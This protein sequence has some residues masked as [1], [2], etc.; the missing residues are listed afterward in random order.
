MAFTFVEPKT[1]RIDIGDG[2]WIEV[3]AQ[4]S[5]GEAKEMRTAGF[6]H[7]QQGDDAAIEAGDGQVK[8]GVNWKRMSLAKLRAYLV[9][10]NAKDGQQ[11]PVPYSTE[12]LAQLDEADFDRIEAAVNAHIVELNDAKKKT[13]SEKSPISS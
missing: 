5:A 1:R 13:A 8:I 10:W 7:M 9:D 3:R 4:L 11:R 2:D 6:T 12:A